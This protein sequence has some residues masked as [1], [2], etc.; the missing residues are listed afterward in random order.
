MHHRT[1][2]QIAP[3]LFLSALT[4]AACNKDEDAPAPTTPGGGGSGTTNTNPSTTPFYTDADAVLAAVRVNT[5]QTTPVGE[6]DIVIGGASAFFSNDQFSTFQNVGAVSCNGES[7]GMQSNNTY[8][9]TPSAT[10]P[11]GIDLTSSNEV[12]WNVGGGGGFN[13]FTYVHTGPFPAVGTIS[14]ATTVVRAN[15]YTLTANSVAGADSVIFMV[16]DVVRT[17]PGNTISHT[18]TAQDLAG[19]SAGQSLMQ[20]VG[21]TADGEDI[22]GKRIYFVKQASRSRS[23]TVQ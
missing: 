10:A 12:S 23:I 11:T 14:S 17:R 16:G 7:L 5:T 4:L 3:L 1:L 9:H 18:F 13:A 15:G 20:V 2:L 22:N 6:F 21:Y 8:V 19:L